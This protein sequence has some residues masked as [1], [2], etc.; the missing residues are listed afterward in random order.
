MSIS[1]TRL[2]RTLILSSLTASAFACSSEPPEV[3]TAAYKIQVAPKNAVLLPNAQL[4]LKAQVFDPANNLMFN[5]RSRPVVVRWKSSDPTAASID[6]RGVITVH[7]E[8]A[9]EITAEFE[10][11]SFE[12]EAEAPTQNGSAQI[13][14]VAA[15]SEVNDLQAIFVSPERIAIDLGETRTLSVTA[16]DGQG[17]PT[18]LDCGGAPTLGHDEPVDASY[19]GSLG[20]E[21]I[22]ATGVRKGFSLL[23]LDCAGYQASPVVVEVKPSVT[24]PDPS[25]STQDSDFGLQPSVALFDE[26]IHLATYDAQHHKLV[27]T[28][29]DG[30]WTSQFIDGEGDYGRQ[31][32]ILLDPVSHRPLI[33]ALEGNGL[34]CWTQDEEGFWTRD[35]VDLDVVD[36]A[37][38]YEYPI[39]GAIDDS[40][41]AFILYHRSTSNTLALA[42]RDPALGVWRV[43]V[44]APGADYGAVDVA[45]DG[46]PR[47]AFRQGGA[48]RFGHRACVGAGWTFE[49]IDVDSLL[50]GTDGQAAPGTYM[51]LAI[52]DDD[53]PQVVYFKGGNLVHGIKTSGQW[54][55]N[56]IEAVELVG[57]HFGFALD[58]R[59]RP[60]VSYF[61]ATEGRMR[62]AHRRDGRWYIDNPTAAAG[63]GTHT[64]IAVDDYDRAQIPY[65]D[66]PRREAGYYVEPHYLDYESPPAI[67]Q[68]PTRADVNE[69]LGRHG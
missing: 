19:D 4:Q 34:S 21:G 13:N 29:F 45:S 27:Y 53:R 18:T 41:R 37:R 10:D 56:V 28:R 11:A 47:V 7:Q 44:I 9:V 55:T 2:G 1:R 69:C 32:K 30:I 51:K 49:D 40:G 54:R 60:R 3:E 23:T 59:L 68:D 42:E 66:Y 22:E 43:E 6:E 57:P 26:V 62:Y 65:Y 15:P 24:I 64:S 58:R 25:P 20:A 12:A 14:A 16:V 35:A 8:K 17:A 38:P 46:R 36:A 61:D 33:C 31:A 5:H 63:V 50:P 48:A 67:T 39:S 52:G